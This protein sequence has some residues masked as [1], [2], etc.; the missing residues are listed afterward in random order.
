MTRS[1]ATFFPLLIA[2]LLG[3]AILF[4]GAPQA[5][6][7]DSGVQLAVQSQL[8]AL[9]A[10]DAVQAFALADP[11]LRT[12]FGSAQEFFDT[13]REQYPMVLKPANVLF[14][15]P[16]SAGTIALQKVRITDVEGSNWLVT[17]VLNRQDDATWLITGCVVQADGHQVTT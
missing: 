16:A 10:D 6:Q 7:D 5:R 3:G 9:A 4:A 11:T 2:A 14:M 12:R 13:V 15:K 17:Y 8:Q 1:P